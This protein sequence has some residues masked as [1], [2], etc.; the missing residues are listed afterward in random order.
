LAGIYIHIPFC[1]QACYYCDFHF[2]T[3]PG[4]REAMVTAILSELEMQKGYLQN[5]TINTIYFGGGTPSILTSGE[6]GNILE[7]INKNFSIAK[8][9][10]ITLEANPDDLSLKKLQ[11][12][13]QLGI[14]RLSIGVQTFHPELLKYLN[15]AHDEHEAI[16][17]ILMARKVGF[18][19]INID[20][21]YNIKSDQHQSLRYDLTKIMEL[22]PE[23][24]SAYSLTIEPNT[25]FGNWKK[26]G[27]IKEVK[28]EYA[29]RQFELVAEVLEENGY[30]QYEISNFAQD[31]KYSQHNSNYWKQV[32]YL[33]VGP[34]AHS[35]DGLSRQYNVA[36]NAQYLKS[37]SSG[38][39]PATKEILDRKTLVNE[40]IMLGLRTMWGCDLELLK[41]KYE[42]DL[43]HQ[44][45]NLVD[46]MFNKGLIKLEK[47]RLLLTKKGKL[48][49]DE[50]TAELLWV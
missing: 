24:I 22:K 11:E 36:N 17:C 50:I 16:H 18:E 37:I 19:K 23:H 48:L 12:L 49:A 29:A 5:E 40:H 25:V 2:S 3:L 15:R 35:F 43:I 42:F 38:N 10:E 26:K 31:Q 6:L 20:L 1:K 30:E 13:F 47:D 32:K 46:G 39:I 33:G 4:Q 34:S 21:I 44:N 28:D 8:N 7:G 14:N 45:E 41:T 9:P 27:K